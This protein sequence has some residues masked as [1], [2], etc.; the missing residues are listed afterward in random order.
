MRRK[1]SVNRRNDLA[2]LLIVALVMALVT[3][4][5]RDLA[6]KP[7]AL[8]DFQSGISEGSTTL[9]IEAGESGSEIGK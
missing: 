9:V 1:L 8:D 5:L 7:R 6:N 2:I 3:F 4:L